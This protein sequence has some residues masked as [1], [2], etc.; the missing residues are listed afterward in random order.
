MKRITLFLCLVL[1][2]APVFAADFG[3]VLDNLSGWSSFDEEPQLQ[4]D[5]AT[6][7]FS[8]PLGA[9]FD[10][11][12]SLRLE[13]RLTPEPSWFGSSSFGIDV[14]RL[15]LMAIYPGNPDHPLTWSFGGGRFNYAFLGEN[16][17]TGRLDGF[18]AKIDV[19]RATYRFALGYLGLM[20]KEDTRT[21]L[22][23]DD[24]ADYNDEAIFFAPPRLIAEATIML[25]ELFARQDFSFGFGSQFD[26]RGWTSEAPSELVHTQYLSFV[27]GG[28]LGRNIFQK[29]HL[30]MGIGEL[31]EGLFVMAAA[32][33]AVSL[34]MPELARAR[35]ELLIEYA[36]GNTGF[37]SIWRPISERQMG[38]VYNV[39]FAD[40][41]S[42]TLD[43]S[44]TP[45]KSLT[46]GV[47]GSLFLRTSMEALQDTSFD[48]ASTASYLGT[49][50]DLYAIFKP[51]SDL[52]ISASS[53]VFLPA[54]GLSYL[55]DASPRWLVSATVTLSL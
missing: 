13:Y 3:L 51:S 49:E 32:G 43:A 39:S 8:T 28:S 23:A 6:A 18:K 9:N 35:L 27:L 40:C 7:W 25:P 22:S 29:A 42:G 55:P 24:V 54:A 34:F 16:I 21:L 41:L 36:S 1:I 26:L 15:E 37:L 10:L 52:S 11:H 19:G 46:A 2:G 14:G 31:G 48:T 17:F 30:D 50:A 4:R 38:F 53:G 44:F 45:L 12:A 47:K 5:R 20:P 33:Y